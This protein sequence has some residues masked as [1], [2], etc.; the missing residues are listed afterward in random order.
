MKKYLLFT[1][2]IWMSISR[3]ALSVDGPIAKIWSQPA[4]FKA[5]E[6]VSIFFDVTGTQLD[7]DAGPVYMWTWSPKEP[8]K[9]NFNNSSDF[10]KL[11]HVSG[12][13]WKWVVTPTVYYGVPSDSI[14]T[15]WLLL[16][17][18][19]GSK[20]TP[21]TGSSITLYDFTT[22]KS[23]GIMD[24]QPQDFTI[25]KPLSILVN[26]LNTWSGCDAGPGVQGALASSDNVHFRSGINDWSVIVENNTANL[27]KTAMT[28]LGDSIYRIDIIPKDY[29]N[30]GDI[31]YQNIKF[32]FANAEA[33][34][35][36]K[37]VECAQFS[38]DVPVQPVPP[39]P[40]LTIFPQKITQKDILYLVRTD[41]EEGVTSL[42]YTIT[43]DTKVISGNFSGSAAK[44]EAY[45]EIGR[46][47][48]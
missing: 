14:T 46:A 34:L 18:K 7:G 33:T 6:Q 25:D 9:G 26:T 24:Y 21:N 28:N 43:G 44:F 39:Q 5:D 3:L 40:E 37:D 41:N 12:N 29:Y 48:V 15:L 45:I 1:I 2:I 22:I 16:K 38:I 42:S 13:I 30:A 27:T 23:T 17:T 11:T 32:V 8:D 10:A 4:I 47:H 19:N 20:Q 31:A 35:V 36:G